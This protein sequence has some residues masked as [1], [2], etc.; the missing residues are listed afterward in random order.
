MS[1]C[2]RWK[3][4]PCVYNSIRETT[5]AKM[6][7]IFLLESK[8]C[9]SIQVEP[10]RKV[11]NDLDDGYNIFMYSLNH[12]SSVNLISIKVEAQN[13]ICHNDDPKA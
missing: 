12:E 13:K 5:F 9:V 10:Q 6:K 2:P 4:Q 1:Y 3:L 7:L 11:G 8:S